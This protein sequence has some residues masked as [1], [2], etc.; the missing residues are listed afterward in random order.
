MPG[1]MT[2]ALE[3]LA[4]LVNDVG[5]AAFLVVADRTEPGAEVE[6]PLLLDPP[7]ALGVGDGRH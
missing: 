4:Q 6:L 2:E 5:V 1:A 3:P 7:P